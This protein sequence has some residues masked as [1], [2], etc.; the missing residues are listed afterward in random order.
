MSAR[1]RTRLGTLELDCELAAPTAAVTCLM[2]PSGAGKTTLLRCLAGL[3]RAAE[4]VVDVDGETWQ[5]D[6]TG[7]FLPP[8]RRRVG[9]WMT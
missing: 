1:V 6:G 3:H 4:A 8:H 5:D 2:G 9:C 7:L